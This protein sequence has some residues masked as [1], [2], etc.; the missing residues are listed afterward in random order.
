[1][2]ILHKIKNTFRITYF[3]FW[4][5]VM[6]VTSINKT[7]DTIGTKL[8]AKSKSIFYGSE[9]VQRSSSHVASYT[10]TLHFKLLESSQG[11]TIFL[12]RPLSIQLKIR[13]SFM[14][15]K[16]TVQIVNE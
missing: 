3:N 5:T 16:N 15:N 12:S 13:L 9:F 2:F 14:L 4:K 8:N 1:M 10:F 11:F 6:V 7:A